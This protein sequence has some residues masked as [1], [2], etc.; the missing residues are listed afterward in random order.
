MTSLIF[1]E[2]FEGFLIGGTETAGEYLERAGMSY[3]GAP[4]GEPDRSTFAV[5]MSVIGR[6]GYRASSTDPVV[7]FGFVARATGGDAKRWRL[8]PD[9]VLT[10]GDQ[11]TLNGVAGSEKTQPGVWFHIEVSID[12][13]QRQAELRVNGVLSA[14]AAL[15]GSLRFVVDFQPEFEAAGGLTIDDL[16]VGAGGVIG[17]VSIQRP[18]SS[19]PAG[20]TLETVGEQVA[21]GASASVSAGDPLA[22]SVIAEVSASDIDG[23]EVSVFADD[24]SKPVPLGLSVATE[25]GIFEGNGGQSWTPGRINSSSFGLRIT[26]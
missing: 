12:K 14:T 3:T 20:R 21:G 1:A 13:P 4:A 26:R 22:V 15:P 25:K 10:L 9:L 23:R 6:I 5:A 24:Q 11:P 19:I 2:G 8:S 18:P 7:G 17:P 16:T